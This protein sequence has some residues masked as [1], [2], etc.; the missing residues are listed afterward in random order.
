M[1]SGNKMLSELLLIARHKDLTMVFVSQNSSNIE[2][3][4][5]RQADF[6]ALKKSSLLQ[7][8][9]E[10]KVIAKVYNEY[11]DKFEKYKDNKGATLIYGHEFIG[12]VDNGLPAFWSKEIGKSFK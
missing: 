7:S 12:F 10:R 5:M 11:A 9:F 6:L 1:S 3:N 4:T 2:I 8:E